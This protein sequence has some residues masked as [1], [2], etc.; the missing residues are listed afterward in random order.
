MHRDSRVARGRALARLL[1][2]GLALVILS[3]LVVGCGGGGRNVTL[4][5][6]YAGSLLIPFPALQKEFEA[7]HPGVTIESEAH[8]SIQVLRQVSDLHQKADVLISADCNL[9][10][11]LLYN[12]SE[13]ETGRPYAD[14]YVK[15][16]TNEMAI[17][18]TEKSQWAA[19]ITS[20]N[21]YQVIARPGVRVGIA[22]PR[23]DANGY[24]A[25]MVLK[26][27]DAVYKKPTLFF[28]FFDG[29]FVTPITVAVEGSTSV[30][31]VPEIVETRP[32]SRIVVRGYS[33]Q[34]LPLL[35][36][37]EI[38]YAVEYLSVIKQHQ[39]KYVTL[40]PELNLGA[41][42][43]SDQYRQVSV[44]LD[45][46]RF[47]TVKPEFPGEPIGYGATVPSDAP[48]PREAAEFIAFLAGP[49]GRRILQS[50]DHP[51]LDP[52]ESDH[53][54]LLP[55]LLKGLCAALR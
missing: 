51:T 36:T 8:G 37:G 54:D 30:I 31:K 45:Y 35:E 32:D 19:E 44:R 9:I 25:L 46:Q 29:A 33:V 11:L 22:D 13:P 15:F 50:F 14:W 28:D 42:G 52:P 4:R 43:Q 18:F 10:P 17:A 40:P 7:S 47:A 48:N 53:V 49:E 1:S 6:I 41:E 27:A 12:T 38:D 24:R 26:L 5:V 39:L 20:D 34:L 2:L 16:A 3:G 23:F 55:P 21:W